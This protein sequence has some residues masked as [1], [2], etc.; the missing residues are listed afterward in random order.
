[1]RSEIFTASPF[2][3]RLEQKQVD[4]EAKS[5]RRNVTKKK[6]SLKRRRHAET[7]EDQGN[8]VNRKQQLRGKRSTKSSRRFLEPPVVQ[9]PAQRVTKFLSTLQL[10]NGYSA[11]VVR[12]GGTRSARHMKVDPSSVTCVDSCN[13]RTLAPWSWDT[14]PY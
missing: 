13:W 8:Y 3:K 14:C 5:R 1:M 7:A 6:L 12:C 2:K 10:K 4:T 11:V 9:S